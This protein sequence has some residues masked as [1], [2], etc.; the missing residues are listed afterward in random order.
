VLEAMAMNMPLLLSDISS[1][2]EQGEDA[3]TYFS[4]TD[5]NDLPQKLLALS[6]KNDAALKAMGEKGKQ[7]ALQHFTLPQHIEGLR[8]IY[9]EALNAAI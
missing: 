4:L 3:A 5:E 7:R 2:R 9:S 8:A 1:F 6:K